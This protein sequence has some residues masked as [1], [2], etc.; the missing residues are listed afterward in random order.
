[1][2]PFSADS[3]LRHPNTYLPSHAYNIP[4]EAELDLPRTLR[5]IGGCS[6]P[7][8]DDIESYGFPSKRNRRRHINEDDIASIMLGNGSEPQRHDLS[9]IPFVSDERHS[10]LGLN[11]SNSDLSTNVCDIED[12]ECEGEQKPLNCIQQTSV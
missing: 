10:L 5:R 12:S 6:S 4:S 1:M 2:F 8:T 9:L 11:T 3:Y 7:D